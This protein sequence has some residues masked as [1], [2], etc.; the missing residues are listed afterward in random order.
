[1]RKSWVNDTLSEAL[2]NN[3]LQAEIRSMILRAENREKITEAVSACLKEQVEN[4]IQDETGKSLQ[5]GK[6]NGAI[7]YP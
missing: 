7:L 3:R 4:Y 5:T 6:S 2:V 1:M